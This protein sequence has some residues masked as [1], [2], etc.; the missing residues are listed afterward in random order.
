MTRADLSRAEVAA[1]G[2]TGAGEVL[3]RAEA[4]R[5]SGVGQD[6]VNAWTEAAAEAFTL[7][8]DRA[9]SL[10]AASGSRH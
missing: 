4:L 10:L 8:L 7:E 9:A 3:A 1:I 5:A 6:L 2:T